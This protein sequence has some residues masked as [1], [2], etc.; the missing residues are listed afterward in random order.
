MT[1]TTRDQIIDGL[2]NNND[3]ILWDKASLTT[4]TK[5]RYGIYWTD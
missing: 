5:A 3:R 4:Q 1:I 2:A